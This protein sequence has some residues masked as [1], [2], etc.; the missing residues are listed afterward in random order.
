MNLVQGFLSILYLSGWIEEEGKYLR[1]RNRS[2]HLS[3]IFVCMVRTCIRKD[4][5]R[6]TFF[7]K[8]YCLNNFFYTTLEELYNVVSA[9]RYF[10]PNT[11]LYCKNRIVVNFSNLVGVHGGAY[12][13]FFFFCLVRRQPII[14]ILFN[15][16][17]FEGIMALITRIISPLN[18]RTC[19]RDRSG[20]PPRDNVQLIR[21]SFHR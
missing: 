17:S 9:S 6:P 15:I 3:H 4:G 19:R 2:G 16:L 1:K 10:I 5:P 8:N 14:I 11:H 12:Y 7:R 13:P 21:T 18:I 20:I